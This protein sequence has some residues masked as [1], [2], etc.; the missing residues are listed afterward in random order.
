MDQTKAAVTL[1]YWL[2]EQMSK[3]KIG[4]VI[5]GKE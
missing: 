1:Q 3:V 2:L 5:T 4:M